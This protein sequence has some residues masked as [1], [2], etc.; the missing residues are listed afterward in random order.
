M[1]HLNQLPRLPSAVCSARCPHAPAGPSRSRSQWLRLACRCTERFRALLVLL[2]SAGIA[3]FCITALGFAIGRLSEA[4]YLVGVAGSLCVFATSVL[5]AH[6]GDP[7]E[8]QRSECQR[9][10][11]PARRM[12]MSVA[13]VRTG[14]ISSS[15]MN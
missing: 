9:A 8:L 3:G 11:A 14:S 13:R 2:G 5:I 7:Y 15:A 10:T 12:T 1:S 6:L 4:Q